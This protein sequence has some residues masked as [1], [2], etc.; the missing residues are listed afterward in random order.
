MASSDH[1]EPSSSDASVTRQSASWALRR[2]AV[3]RST[4]FAGRDGELKYSRKFMTLIFGVAASAA[5][6]VVFAAAV[7]AQPSSSSRPA[8]S[9][10]A[11]AVAASASY[12]SAFE[13]Y[14]PFNDQPVGSWRQANDVVGQIGGWQAYAR[15]GSG[16]PVAGTA[17]TAKA[18]ASVGAEGHGMSAK[19]DMQMPAAVG[20]KPAPLSPAASSPAPATP[21]VRQPTQSPAA[22]RPSSQPKGAS[23]AMS[24]HKM[25]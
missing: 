10:A 11:P 4:Q 12:R 9:A 6:M 16:G 20:G 13:G 7:G 24:G 3:V 5:L 17:P 19:P 23:G 18:G 21:R 15:E 22:D 25:P 8:A 14:R 2:P 1:P